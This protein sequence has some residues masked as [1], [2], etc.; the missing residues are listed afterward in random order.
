MENWQKML[1]EAMPK[2]ELHLHLDGSLR[3]KTALD[4]AREMGWKGFEKPLSWQ[5]MFE[6]TVVHTE[7]HSQKEL[8]A[9]FDIPIELMQTEDALR[10]IA[11]ELIID[12]AA[13]NVRYC[14]IRWAPLIHTAGGL[15]PEQVI[16]AVLEGKKQGEAQTG[17]QA[18]L[19]AT[20]MRSAPPSYNLDLLKAVQPYC[21]HGIVA[22]DLAGPEEAYPDPTDH[23][24][25]F[26]KAKEMGFDITLHC[27]EFLGAAPMLKKAIRE[28]GPSRIAH[29]S[30]AIQDEQLCEEL[31]QRNITL[32][33]CPTSNLQAALYPSYREYPLELLWRR[34]VPVGVNTDDPILSDITL[35]QEYVRLLQNSTLTVKDLWQ[36]NLGALDASF[37]PQKQKDELRKQFLQWAD[38]V[39]ELDGVK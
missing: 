2:A 14:E 38:G 13:D 4:L 26:E 37:A 21:K 9:Y 16:E 29:G 8:I 30:V 22:V 35:S 17:I 18:Q 27:G 6:S 36:M 24:E 10:R 32:D 15:K 3:I 7:L 11:S 1:V 20:G 34:G 28:I 19:I 23:R 5:E 39:E 25:Y 33:L 12:K 31:R